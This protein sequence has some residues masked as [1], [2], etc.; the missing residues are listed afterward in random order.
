MSDRDPCPMLTPP[1]VARRLRVK[2]STVIG[3]IRAGELRA[4]NVAD[5]RA[6]RPRYRID[7]TDLH[8]FIESRQA[9]PQPRAIRRR[10]ATSHVTQYF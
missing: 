2:P 9:G 4:A 1:E 3:W 8:L 5:R 10:P 6:R 7:A